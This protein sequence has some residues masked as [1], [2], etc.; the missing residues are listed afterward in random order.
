MYTKKKNEL[1]AIPTLH[2]TTLHY[3]YTTLH[4]LSIGSVSDR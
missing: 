1:T 3:N 4:M 2:Y